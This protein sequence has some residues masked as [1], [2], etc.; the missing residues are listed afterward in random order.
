MD[1]FQINSIIVFAVFP[2]VLLAGLA[3]AQTV[4]PKEDI[5]KT[6]SEQDNRKSFGYCPDATILDK[7]GVSYSLESCPLSR[8]YIDDWDKISSEDRDIIYNELNANGWRIEDN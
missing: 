6:L 1:K 8:L 3:Y 5:D 2:L 7:Y 4:I